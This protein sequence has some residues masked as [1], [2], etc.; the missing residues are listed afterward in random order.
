M[1][2]TT[3]GYYLVY[4]CVSSKTPCMKY[5]KSSENGSA[6]LKSVSLPL[7]LWPDP[8]GAASEK[9]LNITYQ[10]DDQGRAFIT[11]QAQINEI[12]L[13]LQWTTPTRWLDPLIG[14][15]MDDLTTAM[16]SVHVER[17]NSDFLS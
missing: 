4:Q 3:W 5:S 8:R 9:D 17:G 16:M 7:F 10:L 6:D 12:L 1:C 11:A 15:H 2:V 13:G 14:H